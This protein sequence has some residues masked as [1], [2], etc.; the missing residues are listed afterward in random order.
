MGRSETRRTEAFVSF[1]SPHPQDMETWFSLMSGI[2]D[3]VSLSTMSACADLTMQ[4]MLPPAPGHIS[5]NDLEATEVR[6]VRVYEEHIVKPN[7]NGP[8]RFHDDLRTH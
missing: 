7:M 8:A 4:L 6:T 3:L 1:S 2:S 5:S